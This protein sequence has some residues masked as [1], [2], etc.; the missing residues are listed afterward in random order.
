MEQSIRKSG[1][2]KRSGMR[3]LKAVDTLIDMTTNTSGDRETLNGI[4][5]GTDVSERVGRQVEM[6]SLDIR[7]TGSCTP[8]TGTDQ[9]Q[10]FLVV[11]DHQVN[12]TAPTLQDVLVSASPDSMYNINNRKR[13]S[14]IY[15]K[16]YV[17]NASGEAGS[18]KFFE[19]KISLRPLLET[20]NGGNAG[21]VADIAT[22]AIFAFAMGTNAPGATA[23]AVYGN[24]RMMYYDD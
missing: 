4:A 21:T 16:A 3:E 11:V 8:T 12:G 6:V 5:R 2:T 15:D 7:V 13:F 18:S 10:R 1:K 9:V 19:I 14:I 24:C 22:N 23:G 17:I 20:F